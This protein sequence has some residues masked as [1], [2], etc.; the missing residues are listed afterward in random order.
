L[1]IWGYA[2]FQV[3]LALRLFRWL[4]EQPIDLTYWSYSFGLGST[5]VMTMKFALAGFGSAAVLAPII[6][7]LANVFVLGLGAYGCVRIVKG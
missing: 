5:A 6:F 3:L 2:V 7:V 1:L 4:R